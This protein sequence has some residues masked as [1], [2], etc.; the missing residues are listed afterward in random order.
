RETPRFFEIAT[1]V[2]EALR[3]G[4]GFEVTE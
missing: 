4:H 1:Q 3:K 2:R